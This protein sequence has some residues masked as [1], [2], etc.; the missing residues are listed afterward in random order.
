MEDNSL[1]YLRE[2][3][4]FRFWVKVVL[5]LQ[6]GIIFMFAIEFIRRYY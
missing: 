4:A 5:L 1:K 2:R 3:A 6:S